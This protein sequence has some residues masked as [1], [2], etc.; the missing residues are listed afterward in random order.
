[1]QTLSAWVAIKV[2]QV[3]TV[4]GDKCKYGAEY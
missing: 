2:V 4:S 3:T 1:M